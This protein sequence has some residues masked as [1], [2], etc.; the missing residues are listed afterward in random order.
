M[1]LCTS[2]PAPR[3]KHKIPQKRYGSSSWLFILDL[4]TC[5]ASSLLHE[6][7]L[8]HKAIADKRIEKF[9]D[10]RPGDSIEIKV[11]GNDHGNGEW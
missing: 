4:V 9:H 10:F 5:R 6:I 11:R 2:A 3:I 8:E 1:Q 7:R